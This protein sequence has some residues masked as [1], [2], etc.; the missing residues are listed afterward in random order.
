MQQIQTALQK[1]TNEI[2]VSQN[3]EQRL[4]QSLTPE[5][6]AMI[7]LK[8]KSPAFGIMN[9]QQLIFNAKTLLT[10][11]SV[12]TGWLIPED[13]LDVL[14]DAFT[15]KLILSYPTVNADEVY[16]AFIIGAAQV[17]DWG[18]NLNIGLIDEV[19]IPYLNNRFELSRIEEQKK[20]LPESVSPFKDRDGEMTDWLRI[21]WENVKSS[22]ITNPELI[23]EQ[24]YTWL[25][26]K[27]LVK[28]SKNEKWGYLNKAIAIRRRQLEDRVAEYGHKAEIEQLSAFTEMVKKNELEGIEIV[29]VQTLAKKILLFELI[30][31]TENLNDLLG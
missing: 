22:K 26:E 13:N 24:I 4:M 9:K 25:D 12:V 19:M 21:V 11:I 15:K 30:T 16:H 14:V 3:S 31:N 7:Q 6:K 2:Q 20:Q 23:P 18:K 5:E 29:K 17:K 27:G 10:K 8:Y 28:T 1:S